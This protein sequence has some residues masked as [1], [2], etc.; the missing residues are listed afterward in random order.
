M[1]AKYN[2][3][4]TVQQYAVFEM[5]MQTARQHAAFDIAPQTDKIIRQAGMRYTL[6]ILFDDGTR[7]QHFRNVVAG[8]SDQFDTTIIGLVIGTRTHKGRQEAMMN[9]DDSAT[10][11][12]AQ[13]RRQNLHVTRQHQ[14]IAVVAVDQFSNLVESRLLVVFVH[15]HVMEGNIMPFRHSAQVVV[16]GNDGHDIA[17]QFTCRILVQQIDQAVRHLG[18]HHDNARAFGHVM[19]TPLHTELFGNGGKAL[20][21]MLSIALECDFVAHEETVFDDIG[22]LSRFENGAAV[23]GNKTRNARNDTHTVRT[24]NDQAIGMRHDEQG[25]RNKR[26]Q[27]S[28]TLMLCKEQCFYK[29]LLLATLHKV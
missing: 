2:R 18:N 28:M 13:H 26:D 8:S 20:T 9:I 15:C 11:A 23:F 12:L 5:P 14:C 21:D 4:I 24:G 7:I 1:L 3:T 25:L 10:I 19:Q 17:R 22:V 29:P 6:N 16:V 27:R